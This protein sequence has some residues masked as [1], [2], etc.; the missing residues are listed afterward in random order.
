MSFTGFDYNNKY[1]DEF[2][3]NNLY[4]LLERIKISM[5]YKVRPYVMLYNSHNLDNKHIKLLKELKCFTN[6]VGG[7]YFKQNMLEFFDKRNIDLITENIPS[8]FYDYLKMK[9]INY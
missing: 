8:E 9:F 3:Y 7:S 6:S 4:E 5:I 2:W 1:D